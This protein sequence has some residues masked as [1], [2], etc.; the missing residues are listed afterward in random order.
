MHVGRP[1]PS[2]AEAQGMPGRCVPPALCM[3]CCLTFAV[4]VHASSVI[5]FAAASTQ[6][7]FCE[8]RKA[9]A[10]MEV[11][12][13]QPDCEPEPEEVMTGKG[14]LVEKPMKYF[15]TAHWP[16]SLLVSVRVV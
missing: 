5:C 3:Q 1:S 13:V 2:C 4:C 10:A 14:R 7:P 6:G 16:H 12:A 11:K 9:C 8:V 15:L